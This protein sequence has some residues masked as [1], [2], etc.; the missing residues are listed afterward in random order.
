MVGDLACNDVGSFE[1]VAKRTILSKVNGTV[2]GVWVVK[3]DYIMTGSTIATID[4]DTVDNQTRDAEIALREATIRQESSRLEQLDADDYSAK[5]KSARL[6]LDDAL[7]QREK[8]YDQLEDYTIKAPISG[9]VVAKNKKAGDKIEGGASGSASS[10]GS[11]TLAVI[12]DMS[13]LCFQLDVDE[14]DVKS[15]SVGQE[16]RI[17]ADAVEGKIYRGVVENVSINGTIGTNGVT[18]Y[19]VKVRIQ[20]FDDNLLPG[21]NIEAVIEVASAENVIAVPSGAVNRGNTVYVK[22][23]KDD[24]N[25]RA[26]EGYKTVAV[27][28]GISNDNFVEVKSGLNEGDVVYVTPSSGSEN[29][30]MFPRMGGGMP[31]GAPGGGMPG[32]ANRA[33]GGGNRPGGAPGGGR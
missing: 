23:N 12:Y 20:D 28:L 14:L 7:L 29:T 5:L 2:S 19:P 26:P 4:S 13:S 11:N 22:G 21:M 33:G 3:G 10:S 1:A 8:V 31:G 16:V 32:G 27:E 17:T 24:E 9:T 30:M 18:T 6:Q 25:D 15:V